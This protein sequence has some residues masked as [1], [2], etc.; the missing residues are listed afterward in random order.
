ME[1]WERFLSRYGRE[2]TG[3]TYDVRVGEGVEVRPYWGDEIARMAKLL[4]MKRIDVVGYKPG[5]VWIIEVKPHGGLSAL[6]QLIAYETLYRIK[7]NPTQTI[8]KALVCETVDPDLPG[9]LLQ[10]DITLYRV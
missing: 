1:I 3:F 7:F 6:G 4:T 10:Y 8:R 5:E 2:F 9:L